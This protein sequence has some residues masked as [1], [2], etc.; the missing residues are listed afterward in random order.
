MQVHHWQLFKVSEQ[1][2]WIAT[3]VSSPHNSR[4]STHTALNSRNLSDIRMYSDVL[5]VVVTHQNLPGDAWVHLPHRWGLLG[6]VQSHLLIK[7]VI[8]LRKLALNILNVDEEHL[9]Y[10]EWERFGNII[11]VIHFQC[12]ATSSLTTAWSEQAGR[13]EKWSSTSLFATW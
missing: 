11:F 7:V 10:Y 1:S 5:V 12:S 9:D 6:E 13:K 3:Q 2:L 8:F 4:K